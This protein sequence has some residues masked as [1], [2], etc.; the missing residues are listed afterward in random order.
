MRHPGYMDLAI[1]TLLSRVDALHGV[2][3]WDEVLREPADRTAKDAAIAMGELIEP[4]AR[5]P[6][7]E[8]A[9]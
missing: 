5:L 6:H 7:V 1:N 4:G 9:E 8:P 2:A 3:H